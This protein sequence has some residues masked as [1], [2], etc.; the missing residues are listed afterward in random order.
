MYAVYAVDMLGNLHV[1]NSVYVCVFVGVS[2]FKCYLC[3]CLHLQVLTL[4]TVLG[5]HDIKHRI[6]FDG[7]THFLPKLYP[8]SGCALLSG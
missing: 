6:L 3:Q 5:L 7:I 4:Y 2:V 1:I 8:C